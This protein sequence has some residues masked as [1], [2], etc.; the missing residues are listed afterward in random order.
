MRRLNLFHRI[1][2]AYE[3]STRG[4]GKEQ[5]VGLVGPSLDQGSYGRCGRSIW[6]LKM[7]GRTDVGIS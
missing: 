5:E 1:P 7:P 2:L 6:T 3:L 4:Q